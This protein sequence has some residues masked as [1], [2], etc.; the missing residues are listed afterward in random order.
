MSI[1]QAIGSILV[2]LTVLAFLANLGD[3]PEFTMLESAFTGIMSISGVLDPVFDFGTLLQITTYVIT[4]EG[5]IILFK[6]GSW[7][8]R[9]F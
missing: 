7:L 2:V 8:M 3:V 5:F 6:A 9:F 1:F 4:I